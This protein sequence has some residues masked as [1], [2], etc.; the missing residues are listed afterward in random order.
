MSDDE[1]TPKETR[2]TDE[3]IKR[4]P[5]AV[6]LEIMLKRER[7]Q[8]N[9]AA[10]LE[11]ERNRAIMGFIYGFMVFAL[12]HFF[13]LD[14]MLLVA[15][16]TVAGAVAGYFIVKRRWNYLIAMVLFGAVSIVG[17][18]TG[19]FLGYMKPQDLMFMAAC[20]GVL[21]GAGMVLVHMVEGDRRKSEMF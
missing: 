21:C 8:G 10:F 17:S 9:S 19:L 20:W 7:T 1:H 14:N 15:A 2:L 6:Q 5:Q 3:E 4:L 18:M 13:I 12:A 16:T 11:R